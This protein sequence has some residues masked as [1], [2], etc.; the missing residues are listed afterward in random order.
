MK[1]LFEVVAAL[2]TIAVP[3]AMQAQEGCYVIPTQECAYVAQ[4]Q[5]YYAPLAAEGFYVGGFA[6]ANFLDL[7]S[8]HVKANDHSV[9]AKVCGDTG[10][11]VGLTL[12]FKSCYG[13][14]VE[15]EVAYRRNELNKL[16]L[17]FGSTKDQTHTTLISHTKAHGHLRTWSYMGNAYYDFATT[18]VVSPYVG[19]GIGYD[20]VRGELRVGSEK[21]THKRRGLSWQTM[22]GLN[23][24]LS[25]TVA[26]N[27]EYK[28][29]MSKAKAKNN[30]RDHTL[31][32]GVKRYF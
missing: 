21:D 23:Y 15:G 10:Y 12:G 24:D 22:A 25:D 30:D 5:G 20:E 19:A 2:I 3:T 4:P 28:L 18:C 31:A 17:N 14:R 8:Q 27:L 26:L 6:G 7:R 29:H 13:V 9:R 16:K 32:V 1:K 11:A